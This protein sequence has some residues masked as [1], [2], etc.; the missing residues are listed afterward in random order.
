MEDEKTM[1]G[2]DPVMEFWGE[3]QGILISNLGNSKDSITIHKGHQETCH[4]R[5]KDNLQT[6]P[7]RKWFWNASLPNL[8]IKRKAWATTR[9]KEPSFGK[10][11]MN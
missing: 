6:V 11:G 3:A 8:F 2:A 1:D 10:M 5:R 7:S 9:E 4:D